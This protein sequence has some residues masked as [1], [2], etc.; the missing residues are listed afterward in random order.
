MKKR[1]TKKIR[2]WGI[3]QGVGFRPFVAKL[4][5]RLCMKGKVRNLGGI[6]EICVTDTAERIAI[7]ISEIE[8]EKLVPSEIVY[9]KV[10]DEAFTEY[11]NFTIESSG[12]GGDEY[13]MIPADMAIC[14]DCLTEMHSLQNRRF[15]HPFISCMVCGPRY[16]IA[17]TFP[18]DRCNTTQ[19][20]FPMCDIC[21]KEYADVSDRRYHA[22][23][24][25]CNDC[26]PY[27]RMYIR[28]KGTMFK[29][30]A[31]IGTSVNKFAEKNIEA[32]LM[33]F[34]PEGKKHK[35]ADDD[36][37][38]AKIADILKND[39]VIAYKS[40]GGY[41]FMADPLNDAAVRKLRHIK[42]REEKPFAVMFHD[43]SQ[44]R[45][46]CSMDAAEE[47]L[48]VS[49]ARPI[50]LLERKAS[51]CAELDKSRFIGSF[52]PSMGAQYMI[53]ER[54]GGPLIATS[55]NISSM[56][57]IK[58][59][60]DM[61]E[62][63]RK[64]TNIDALVYND[65]KIRTSVDDSVVRV[66]DGQ[67]QM[68]RRS[69]G[70][71]PVPVF[72]PWAISSE[73][74]EEALQRKCAGHGENKS[75]GSKGAVQRRTGD[76]ILACGAQLKNSFALSKG[77]FA[78]ISQ[79]FGDMD[80]I[81]N[82]STYRENIK[83]MSELF[84]I[85]PERIACDLHPLYFTTKFAEELSEKE[86]L[87]L[88]KVQHHQAHVA[89]VMAEH[90][91]VEPVIGVS[92]DG[93]GYGSDGAIWGGEFLL[94]EGSE[95]TRLSHIKY[96]NMIGGDGAIR[97]GWKS[98]FGY[99]HAFE[100][101]YLKKNSEN[102]IMVDISDIINFSEKNGTLK[103][104]SN[105]RLVIKRAIAEDINTIKSSSMGRLFDA[106]AAMLGICQ[107]NSYE[108]Q[109]AIMLEDAAARAK[110]GGSGNEADILAY[111]FHKKIADMIINECTKAS[112]KTG[113]FKAALTGGVFQNKIL[114]ELALAGLRK[115]GIMPYYNIS[116]SPNDGGIVLGQIY[117]AMQHKY[118]TGI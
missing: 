48:I 66:I 94:C 27:L 7:F 60:Y 39:G 75:H 101:G 112:E 6:V 23:T 64:D 59:D 58:E 78:Y 8:K 31:E 38:I 49:S 4:A 80:S 86:G 34:L 116:V 3:V 55:A 53:L 20:D 51:C 91:L 52:L 12:Y 30:T 100:N 21:S 18:Y 84:R 90:G 29:S 104:Y 46:Y 105:E 82:Q 115:N 36:K 110:A 96:I 102:E 103:K 37:I 95:Y 71:V 67:P 73:R 89:S 28:K 61:L 26:G 92:F 83:K 118:N 33:S 68:I 15:T 32:E 10:E 76:S 45:N 11:K 93:T 47:K 70:Y 79:F 16:T 19:R 41:N 114:M 69:K 42:N 14:H 65:R 40:M 97:D 74:N 117:V 111:A 17:E 43:C 108:G 2:I 1:S 87:T 99:M 13:A 98:A 109:C 77:P 9:I 57:I 35:S 63:M 107:E 72:V 106:V 22:Q 62:M 44:V 85:K 24:I 50:I 56:P 25:S 5:E 81:E 54:F 88:L 113:V